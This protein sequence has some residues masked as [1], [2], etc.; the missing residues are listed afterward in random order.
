M[1]FRSP[2]AVRRPAQEAGAQTE[3]VLLE[4]GCS[5]EEIARWK[6]AGIIA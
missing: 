6:E 3:E 2:P 4:L 5:W 1:L